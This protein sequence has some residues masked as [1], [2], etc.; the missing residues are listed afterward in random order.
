[1]SWSSTS[2]ACA[3]FAVHL[4]LAAAAFAEPLGVLGP[5]FSPAG[6]LAG[7]RM[8][9]AA[10]LLAV[11]ASSSSGNDE[12]ANPGPTIEASDRG[13]LAGGELA[14]ERRQHTGTL[15]PDGRVAVLG[16]ID[17][18]EM[19][20]ATIEVWSTDGPADPSHEE[21]DRATLGP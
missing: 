21:A 12:K 2:A 5:G 20:L 14:E 1:M 11:A 10:G 4:L 16:G 9:H 8:A 6:E 18:Q 13:L 3:G 19:G 15:L 7:P 17:E